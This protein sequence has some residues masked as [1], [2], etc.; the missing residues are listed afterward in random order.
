MNIHIYAI[1]DVMTSIN[2]VVLN[3]VCIAETKS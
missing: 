3:L 2:I 1:A